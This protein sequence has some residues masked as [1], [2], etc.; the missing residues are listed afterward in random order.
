MLGVISILVGLI[1]GVMVSLIFKHLRFM[2]VSPIIETFIIFALCL[3]AYFTSELLVIGGIQMSGIISL[4]TC[5][6][7][8]AHYSYYNLSP[9]GKIAT[10]LTFSFLGEMCEAAVYSYVGI[11]LYSM[12]PTWWSFSFIFIQLGIII[13]GRIFGVMCTFYTCRCCFRKK[14][15]SFWELVFITYAGMI[16]GA[17]ALALV[18][19][20]PNV[21]N[22]ENCPDPQYCYSVENYQLAVST[23][24]TLV[25][26]TTLLFGTFMDP[27]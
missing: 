3:T 12:I 23:T 9:Q 11:A 21:G 4:L 1:Y 22:P 6:I 14:T 7:F 10:T 20:I 19:K 25:M 5:G 17:I 24:L 8:N 18:L 15:I 2:T 26:L 27:V 16:R 13:G